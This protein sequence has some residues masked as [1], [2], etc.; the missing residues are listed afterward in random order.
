MQTETCKLGVIRLSTCWLLIVVH[1]WMKHQIENILLC[2][3]YLLSF[4]IKLI[5][6]PISTPSDPSKVISPTIVHVTYNSITISWGSPTEENG[7]ISH[8]EVNY[9]EDSRS[10]A[11]CSGSASPPSSLTNAFTQINVTSLRTQENVPS[12]TPYTCYSFQVRAVVEF[13]NE[14]LL[15]AIHVELFGFTDATS[16]LCMILLNTKTQI[17]LSFLFLCRTFCC[18]KPYHCWYHPQFNQT[19][20]DCSC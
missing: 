18:E 14:L 7:C 9:I 11:D 10:A 5:L 20:M 17:T 15:G 1:L 19:V 16:K 2:S 8:Y 6:R 4:F 13:R 3:Q 12:L